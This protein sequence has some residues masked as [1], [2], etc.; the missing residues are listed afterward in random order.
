MHEPDLKKLITG[1]LVLAVAAGSGTILLSQFL[2]TD[3]NTRPQ[4]PA[5]TLTNAFLK[6]DVASLEN[7]GVGGY[8]NL[9]QNLADDIAKK[10][11]QNNLN[12]PS[13]T[14][15]AQSISV[16]E[17]IN[18]VIS[19]YLD[20]SSIDPAKI[21]S[22]KV[23][24]KRLQVIKNPSKDDVSNYFTNIQAILSRF[25]SQEFKN[26]NDQA[27]N[28]GGESLLGSFVLFYSD[29]ET[30]LY[31]LKVPEPELNFHKDFIL[32]VDIPATL[33]SQNINDDPL[34]A[35][36]V[37]SSSKQLLED[38]NTDILKE[39]DIIKLTSPLSYERSG[40]FAQILGLQKAYATG[41][42]VIDILGL[43]QHILSVLYANL[44]YYLNYDS[45][46]SKILTEQLKDK[47]LKAVV[48]SILNWANGGSS[49]GSPTF[50]TNWSGFLKS[51]Y[52]NAADAAIADVT[53]GV[54]EP[55]RTQIQL[56]LYSLYGESAVGKVVR[57]PQLSDISA[58]TLERTV[59]NLDDFYGDFSQGGWAGYLALTDLSGNNPYSALYVSSQAV[60]QAAQQQQEADKAKA[61]AGN[62]Y[63]GTERCA[64][65]ADPVDGYCGD[66]SAAE[67]TTPG[68]NIA[69]ST[70]ESLTSAIQRIVNANDWKSLALQLAK[71]AITKITSSG[72]K[73]IRY[74][75]ATGSV[76]V[77]KYASCSGYQLGSQDYLDCI[78]N[79]DQAN[80]LGG[81]HGN[82]ELLLTQSKQALADASATLDYMK[83]SLDAATTSIGILNSIA[84][85]SSQCPTE[86]ATAKNALLDL[87]Q[88]YSDLLIKA[89]DLISQ[90]SALSN[91]I[92]D[93]EGHD[94][95]DQDFFL[96]KL[97]EFNSQFGGPQAFAQAKGDAQ[98]QAQDLQD[99]LQQSSDLLKAC[100][101]H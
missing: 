17:D 47:L 7:S 9:T 74:G 18:S 93:V 54:C 40:V 82:R 14:G 23:D 20:S 46:Y 53:S 5:L 29:I 78:K 52:V 94:P 98:A 60:G 12:G 81:G 75:G 67:I 28:G 68:T 37:L 49:G 30:K 69:Q 92:S 45:W 87:N 61:T 16:P 35:S 72:N 62:G 8:Q 95:Q 22:P 34:M 101:A 39:L 13:A 25:Q 84:S 48:N 66:G 57:K 89:S 43:V 6:G 21:P 100:L 86:A 50:V 44:N 77:D 27:Q 90:I 59:S 63:V 64:N 2:P 51:S 83:I 80:G 26:I 55:F 15:T 79:I 91:F 56:Q 11:I 73:G 71:F 88:E 70:S 1:F 33:F 97:D 96:T 31:D 19:Q 38:T 58:C 76:P 36:L 41:I 3:A 24:E 32:L 85:S 42:P 65:G 10:V 4:T 99:K